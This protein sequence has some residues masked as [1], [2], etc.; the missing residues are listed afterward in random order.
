MDSLILR[1]ERDYAY[2]LLLNG[3]Y[4]K[5]Y[6][7]TLKVIEHAKNLNDAEAVATSQKNIGWY[8]YTIQ[9]DNTKAYQYYYESSKYFFEY[10]S[11]F[12]KA[13][14]LYAIAVVQDLEKDY[15]GSEENG[16]KALRIV[17]KLEQTQKNKTLKYQLL[18]LLGTVTYKLENYDKSIA[19]HNQ[20]LEV[21]DEL[22]D[23]VDLRYT[24][25]N[26]L[27][28]PYRK[29][30]QY[31]KALELFEE[32]LSKEDLKAND[33]LFYALI[34]D[35]F[36][37]TK[38]LKGDYNFSNLESDFK[39]ALKIADSLDDPYTK[40]AA[41]IDLAKFYKGNKRRDS[42]YKYAKQSYK[43]SKDIPI[44]E[45]YLESM[46]ILAELTKN[47]TS[48]A[49]LQEHIKLSDSLLKNERLVR[50]KFARIKYE[51]DQL[52]AENEQISK[53][54]LYLILLSLGLLLAAIL[55][56][57][58]ITQRARNKELKLMQM[59][60]EANEA[61]YNV[62]LNQQDKIEEARSNE[63]KRVSLELHDG[64][65]GRLFGTRLSL[66]S[67]NIKSDKD[68]ISTRA[69]YI[70]ELKIIEED[71]RKISHEL[72]VDFSGGS[73]FNEVLKE[74]IETQARAYGLSYNFNVDGDI[75]W[76]AI[77]NKVKINIYRIV[78]ESMQ[79]VYKHAQA[80][81]L[82]ISIS[83]KSNKLFIE[84]NDD[85]KGFDTNKGRKGIGLK[86]MNSRV[87]DMNGDIHVT[88]GLNEGTTVTVKVPYEI[89]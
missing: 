12:E 14:I 59:Q 15:L 75:N 41:S 37:F 6:N 57:I 31:D 76:D 47:E 30:E 54:N 88:S 1:A 49:Y 81:S 80:S 11:P 27:A 51:T 66:D 82:N 3:D 83:L 13:D 55:I 34:L 4:E 87:K 46:L 56:Y 69:K 9:D 32:L 36:A 62:L 60:Q 42:A 26:N 84:I 21:V 7:Q 43:I 73:G 74:L 25:Y 16:I 67:I 78:Q 63:K 89:K 77:P 20:A 18:D 61:I 19:Y 70:K 48:K 39:K 72:S 29:L 64:I 22:K 23:R 24:S 2:N 40:L 44:N 86:N 35:N 28:Q 71:I 85:G 5:F 17:N 65:L 33:Y 52:E 68:A 8:Y 10:G 58:I 53:E 50:N 79:N 45:L 38:F